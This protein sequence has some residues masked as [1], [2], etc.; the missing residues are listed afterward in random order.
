[1]R[2]GGKTR[3]TLGEAVFGGGV[4]WGGGPEGCAHRNRVYSPNDTYGSADQQLDCERRPVAGGEGIWAFP[5]RRSRTALVFVCG[6]CVRK[7]FVFRRTSLNHRS[8]I[9][10][11]LGW[12]FRSFF[13]PS[14]Q[15]SSGDSDSKELAENDVLSAGGYGV[16]AVAI[17]PGFLRLETMLER[18]GVT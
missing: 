7:C 18:F 16:A 14:R 13:P 15:V 6:S 2:V 9:S 8:R 5:V 12:K 1:M 10:I 3:I 4:I 11:L 17:T